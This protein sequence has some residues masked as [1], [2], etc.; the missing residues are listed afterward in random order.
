MLLR[1]N[2]QKLEKP[3]IEYYS[4]IFNV[5]PVALSEEIQRTIQEVYGLPDNRIPVV[6][7]GIDLSR[8]I[9]KESYARKD[10]FTVL[11]IGRFMDV[12]NHELLLRSFARFKGQH[13][14]ARLSCWGW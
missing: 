5:V 13:S 14:D 4:A 12:K 8:C 7:N 9:V 6:F 2:R 10:S 3:L 1:K 11:H